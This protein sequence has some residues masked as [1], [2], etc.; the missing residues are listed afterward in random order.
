MQGMPMM[1]TLL[2]ELINAW[3]SSS[4]FPLVSG[5]NFSTNKIAINATPANK[6][7]VPAGLQVM[8]KL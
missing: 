2:Y 3:I 7:Y 1:L 8:R 5:T 6:K 4:V